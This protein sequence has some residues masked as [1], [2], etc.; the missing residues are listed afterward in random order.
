MAMTAKVFNK[1]YPIGT[2]VKYRNIAD[3]PWITTETRS[4]AWDLGNGEPVV[5][6]K[7]KAGGVCIDSLFLRPTP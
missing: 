3:E 2:K 7:G 4:E 6:I 5:K 1:L